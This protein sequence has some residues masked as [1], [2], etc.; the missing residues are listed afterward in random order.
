MKTRFPRLAKA[1]ALLVFFALGLAWSAPVLADDEARPVV[2]AAPA[3]AVRVRL[4]MLRV[5][6][7]KSGYVMTISERG[8]EGIQS[9][10]LAEQRAKSAS[11]L[12]GFCVPR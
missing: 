2:P 9:A 4:P 12:A 6:E 10:V 7:I 1:G 3:D 5:G 8:M 11:P